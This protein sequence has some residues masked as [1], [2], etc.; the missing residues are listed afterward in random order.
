[1]PERAH[2]EHPVWAEIAPELRPGEFRFPY[3][4]DVDFLRLLSR[5][6][7]ACG[8]PF[9]IVSDH[10]P[11]DRNA[12][13]GGATKSAHM[14][15]P[16]AAVDLRVLSN[17]ERFRLVRAAIEHGVTRIGVYPPTPS[18]RAGY[19]KGAGSVHLDASRTNPSPRMWMEA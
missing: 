12:A 18:Q 8:V 5:I 15:E 13:A 6:R 16:C 9:R 7:R 19:G 1:M 14:E 10:R 3:L 11:P 4:M 17:E 2:H